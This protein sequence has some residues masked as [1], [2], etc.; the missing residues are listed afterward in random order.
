MNAAGTAVPPPVLTTTL[1]SASVGNT[2]K[3][4]VT[5]FAASTVTWQVPVP[6]QPAPLQPANTE[7]P[8]GVAVSV[9]SV[10]G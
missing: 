4:A 7:P 3:V 1:F 9:T 6:A 10:P 8:V 5:V 2:P